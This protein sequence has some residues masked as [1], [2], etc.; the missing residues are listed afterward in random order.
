M[1]EL[2]ENNHYDSVRLNHHLDQKM[3]TRV[4]TAHVPTD[5]AERVDQLAKQLERSRGWIVKQAL[6]AWVEEEAI[7]RRLILEA[8]EDIAQGDVVDHETVKAWV[9]SLGTKNPKKLPLS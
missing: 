6:S 1:F 2:I 3:E 7:K 5:L 9:D 8:M 4:I